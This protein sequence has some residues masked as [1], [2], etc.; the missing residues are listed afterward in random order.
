[1]KVGSNFLYELG[2][3]SVQIPL[4]ALL[5]AANKFRGFAITIFPP[6]LLLNKMCGTVARLCADLENNL[7]E[8]IFLLLRDMRHS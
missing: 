8:H 2:T 1:M 3:C 6:R 5:A 7:N 4:T